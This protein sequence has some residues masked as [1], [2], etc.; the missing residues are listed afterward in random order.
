[1]PDGVYFSRREGILHRRQELKADT[2]ARHRCWNQ[3]MP[4]PK[5]LDRAAEPSLAPM[6]Q[7]CHLR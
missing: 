2:L 1:M 6:T 7:L 4:G 3:G 5:G